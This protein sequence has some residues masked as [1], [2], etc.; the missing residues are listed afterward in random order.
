MSVFIAAAGLVCAAGLSLAEGAAA[1]RARLG[2]MAEI[3]WLDRRFEPFIVAKV[4]DDGLPPLAAALAGLPL[5][6][7]EARMLR[8]GHAALADLFAGLPPD[9]PAA[10]LLLG[11]GEH[12]STRPID[13]SDF[14]GK[15]ATQVG[16]CFVPAASVAATCGRAAG[17][18][19]LAQGVRRIAA[20]QAEWVLVGGLDSLVDLY[21]LGSFDRDRRIRG[22]TVSDG[23]TPGE[24]AAF[25]LLASE[26]ALRKHGLAPLAR[27]AGCG[28]GHEAGHL[29]AEQAYL[30]DG[31]A[32]AVGAALDAAASAA[33]VETVYCSFNGERYW[34][35]EFGVARIRNAECFAAETRMEHPA[36]CFGDLGGAHGAALVA[37]AAHGL[38]AGYR[39]GPLLAYASSDK[40]DRAAVVLDRIS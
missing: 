20:G 17:L 34:A 30:G 35:R 10:P 12:D 13:P 18:Q 27:V 11:L 29:Y 2:C 33:P 3:P 38:A 4:P 5:Q 28:A 6:P 1:A 14:V 15:L 7:R 9:V 32:A 39:N 21:L 40:G 25:L 16:P 36:E 19:A 31:L 24:G 26:A 23:F 8:L 37:L 22:E